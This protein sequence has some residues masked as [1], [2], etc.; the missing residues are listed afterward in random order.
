MNRQ[1]FTTL[2][3]FM[4]LAFGFLIGRPMKEM[5]WV[6]ASIAGLVLTFVAMFIGMVLTH[7][8]LYT[9]MRATEERYKEMEEKRK[10]FEERMRELFGRQSIIYDEALLE[11]AKAVCQKVANKILTKHF[12]GLAKES[13][14]A[15]LFKSVDDIV[16]NEI[17]R[18][19]H[20]LENAPNPFE[21]SDH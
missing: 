13:K 10:N 15:E 20:E 16:E 7:M 6:G 21:D 18:A 1:T 3:F 11:F 12:D 4:M 14:R 5:S 17:T 2:T 9:K 19:G 8:H